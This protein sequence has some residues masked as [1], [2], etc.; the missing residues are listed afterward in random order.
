[1]MLLLNAG[2]HPNV[3][4]APGYFKEFVFNSFQEES[5]PIGGTQLLGIVINM[6]QTSPG[7]HETKIRSL[8][9]CL[10]S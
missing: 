6:Q 9:K 10:V 2:S 1:M 5:I 3:G 4:T 8:I 7:V